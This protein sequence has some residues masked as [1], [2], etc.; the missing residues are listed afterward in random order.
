MVTDDKMVN[1]QKTEECY[2]REKC[3]Y[4][5]LPDYIGKQNWLKKVTNPHTNIFYKLSYLPIEWRKNKEDKPY[6][7]KQANQII[8][9][10]TADGKEWLKSKQQWIAI[11]S[12]GNEIMESFT[13]LEEWD[14]LEFEYGMK[15]VDPKILMV[16]KSMGS[17]VLK[18]TKSI[19]IFPLL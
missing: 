17:L 6:P 1:Y 15:S 11:D 3:K 5:K 12:Q 2:V 4:E 8:R 16:Q 14:E 7:I 18:A 19:M 10:K 9:V 13:D